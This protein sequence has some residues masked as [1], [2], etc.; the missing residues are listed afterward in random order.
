MPQIV[1]LN[2]ELMFVGNFR[3]CSAFL[4]V[5]TIRLLKILLDDDLFRYCA[6]LGIGD[7]EKDAWSIMLQSVMHGLRA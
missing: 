4:I 7:K 5:G 6:F 3:L 2:I 1:F